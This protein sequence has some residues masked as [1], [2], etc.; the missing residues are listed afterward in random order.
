MEYQKNVN[1]DDVT[2]DEQTVDHDNNY[3]LKKPNDVCP[4]NQNAVLNNYSNVMFAK[5]FLDFVNVHHYKKND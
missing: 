3:F 5:N 1:V 4:K 2:M